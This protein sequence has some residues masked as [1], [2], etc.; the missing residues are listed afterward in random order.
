MVQWISG[1]VD[2]WISERCM[3]VTSIR[4]DV[5]LKA[6]QIARCKGKW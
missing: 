1:L 3:Y 2:Q 4:L 5:L 6:N